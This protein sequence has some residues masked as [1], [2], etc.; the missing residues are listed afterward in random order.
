MGR[1][2][3]QGSALSSSTKPPGIARRIPRERRLACEP[4]LSQQTTSKR[5]ASDPT[6]GQAR[7]TG[8]ASGMP[9][10]CRVVTSLARMLQEAAAG[11][12]RCRLRQATTGRRRPTVD[13][14]TDGAD[15]R[16][17]RS[18]TDAARR[19]APWRGRSAAPLV[20]GRG[21]GWQKRPPAP[22]GCGRP[23]LRKAYCV[24]AVAGAAPMG[25]EPPGAGPAAAGTDPAAG[26]DPLPG[27]GPIGVLDTPGSPFGSVMKPIR[28]RP[29]RAASP[30]TWATV[31]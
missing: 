11:R 31:S 19:S 27:A 10:Q 16:C 9:G 29:T 5:P 14:H 15:R 23:L 28:A 3:A 6:R 17:C 13:G 26:A 4:P 18:T 2:G 12:R 20:K 8:A 7:D 22:G 1:T 30:R 24:P 21:R 25:A